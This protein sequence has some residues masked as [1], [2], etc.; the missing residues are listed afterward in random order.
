MI[1]DD[2]GIVDIP[3]NALNHRCSNS[4]DSI[5]EISR[6]GLLA[7]EWFGELESEREWCFCTFI[8]RMKGNNYPY[9][10]DLAEDDKSRLNI[11][12][13]IILFFDEENP[14]M[15]YLLHLDYFEFEHQNTRKS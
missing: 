5:R 11:G 13:N 3:K 8:S 6:Y 7:S 12:E 2:N 15:E 1:I 4:M 10:G 9:H 14:I